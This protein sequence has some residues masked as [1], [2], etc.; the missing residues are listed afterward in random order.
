MTSVTVRVPMP[1]RS[2]TGGADEVEVEARTVGDALQVLGRRYA[3]LLE[4]IVD[5]D[6]TV[7]RFV[8]IYVGEIDIRELGGLDATLQGGEV[9]SVVPAVAG[10][11]G[12][13]LTLG[14]PRL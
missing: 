12:R 5:V 2:F 11:S 7:R 1:L 3:G 14:V 9:V 4:R 10:G 6:G 13:P 8:N